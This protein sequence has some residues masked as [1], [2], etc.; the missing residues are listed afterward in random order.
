MKSCIPVHHATK[1]TA[2]SPALPNER[3]SINRRIMQSPRYPRPSFDTQPLIHNAYNSRLGEE[4]RRGRGNKATLNKNLYSCVKKAQLVLPTTPAFCLPRPLLILRYEFKSTYDTCTQ[5][6]RKAIIKK[7]K[8][9]RATYC[10]GTPAAWL[11]CASA[12]AVLG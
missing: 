8:H 12:C 9:S 3:E 6:K 10:N 2:S 5:K 4:T 7:M 1:S 11:G